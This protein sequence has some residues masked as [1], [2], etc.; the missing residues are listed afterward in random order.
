MVR[1]LGLALLLLTTAL[2]AGP[3]VAAAA[4][5]ETWVAV[6]WGGLSV[7]APAEVQLP[8]ARLS[9]AAVTVAAPA[10]GIHVVDSRGG[11]PGWT[12]VAAAGPPV[13]ARGEPLEASLMVVPEAGTV[14]AGVRLGDPATLDAPRTLAE[15]LPGYGAGSWTLTPTIRLTVPPDAA[16]GVYATTL[17]VTIS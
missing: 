6:T 7:Q 8:P 13:D 16:S 4:Q 5:S 14:P 2:A 9:G 11:N 17:V 12:L 15:A 3:G 10:G 1:E